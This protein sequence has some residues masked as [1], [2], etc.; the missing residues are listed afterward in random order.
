MTTP[1]VMKVRRGTTLTEQEWKEA[2]TSAI[3]Q[4]YREAWVR[5]D[6]SLR[7]KAASEMADKLLST[8][9]I[10]KKQV[11]TNEVLRSMTVSGPSTDECEE[12][13]KM[14]DS[15]ITVREVDVRFVDDVQKGLVLWVAK[16]WGWAQKK[17]ESKNDDFTPTQSTTT[18]IGVR[19]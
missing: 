3:L 8:A 19:G 16:A 14:L 10:C 4:R 15:L 12:A 17:A 18:A 7:R 13:V 6:Q 5:K 9:G 2:Y 11:Q 1:F